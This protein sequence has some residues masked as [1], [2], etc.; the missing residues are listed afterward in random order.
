MCA[1]DT[2]VVGE[3]ETIGSATK[4]CELLDCVAA[5]AQPDSHGSYTVRRNRELIESAC[6][7]A[8]RLPFNLNPCVL[9]WHDVDMRLRSRQA[10]I[11]IN[12]SEAY[13]HN[14]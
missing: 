9:G 4:K 13:E 10:V 5:N 2:I 12:M 14:F 8:N 3:K 6:L 7:R 1:G 11:S